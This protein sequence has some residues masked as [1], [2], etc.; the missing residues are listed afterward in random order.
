MNREILFR[1]KRI[2]D[3]E[4]FEGDLYKRTITTPKSKNVIYHIVELNYDFADEDEF[5]PISQSGFEEVVIPE[6]VGQYTGLTDKNGK[7]VFEGDILKNGYGGIRVVVFMNT[8]F[9]LKNINNNQCSSWAYMDKHEIIGNVH[10]NPELL[11]GE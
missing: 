2:A 9:I 5:E 11:K 6:T 3:G 10:D 8:R 7:K 4:W 1:G